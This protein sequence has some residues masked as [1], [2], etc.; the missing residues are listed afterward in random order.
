MLVSLCLEVEESLLRHWIDQLLQHFVL[1]RHL[2]VFV[3]KLR[4]FWYGNLWWWDQSAG[5]ATSDKAIRVIR[6]IR[7]V[8]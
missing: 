1:R 8:K 7:L 4:G 2:R 6:S 3:L 5:K